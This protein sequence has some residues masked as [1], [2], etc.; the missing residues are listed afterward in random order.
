L[1][2]HANEL[3]IIDGVLGKYLGE[4]VDGQKKAEYL[5]AIAEKRAFISIKLSPWRW[6]Q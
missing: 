1:I 5:R 3:E 2:V 4:I 6:C